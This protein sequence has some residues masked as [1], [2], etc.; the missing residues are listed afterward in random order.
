MAGQLT[1]NCVELPG[2]LVGAGDLAPQLENLT[3]QLRLNQMFVVMCV[4]V[5]CSC[6]TRSSP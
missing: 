1:F 3:S 6:K 2:L 5:Y 4:Y